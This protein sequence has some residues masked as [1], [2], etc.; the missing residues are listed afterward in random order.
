MS[1]ATQYSY[2]VLS[3]LFSDRV[4]KLK[5]QIKQSYFT[6]PAQMQLYTFCT[7]FYAST[8]TVPTVQ[9]VEDAFKDKLWDIQQEV[10]TILGKLNVLIDDALFEH[11]L[12]NFIQDHKISLLVSN[13][14]KVANVQ[15]IGFD[16]VL[17]DTRKVLNTITGIENSKLNIYNSDI[18]DDVDSFLTRTFDKT[19][20]TPGI[21]VR[22]PIINRITGG[23]QPKRLWVIAGASGE[24]KSTYLKNLAYDSLIAGANTF[25]CTVE[26]DQDQVLRV[27]TTIHV[28][29][30]YSVILES[31]KY[32]TYTAEEEKLFRQAQED[33]LSLSSNITIFELPQRY[34]YSNFESMLT[35]QNSIKKIDAV[36]L[37]YLL[38]LKPDS[39]RSQQHEESEQ[40][41][42]EARQL[43][44]GFDGGRGIFVCTAHQVN[45]EGWKKAKKRGHYVAEDLAKTVAA[46]QAPDLVIA[47]Y[48]D[49]E[50]RS[51]N[52]LRQ[53]LLKNRGGEFYNEPWICPIQLECGIINPPLDMDDIPKDLKL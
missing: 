48:L 5:A 24:C 29:R 37:D 47:N 28:F 14:K 17:D 2:N 31:A 23:M 21:P 6:D 7:E 50:L 1:E 33:F 35:Q 44:N 11:S 38:L 15:S 4:I 3:G 42:N 46:Q 26:E 8:K 22:N 30:K 34:S 40:L 20:D 41:Y 39:K 49:P 32:K 18:K 27:L 45:R 9:V 12:Q 51:Q 13:S 43:A 10:K 25:Y 53:N 16:K 19:I 52:E 36:F